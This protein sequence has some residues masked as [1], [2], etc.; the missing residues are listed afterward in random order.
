MAVLLAALIHIYKSVCMRIFFTE[1]KTFP[2]FIKT[3]YV[4]YKTVSPLPKQM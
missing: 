4:F 2:E 1:K 3:K